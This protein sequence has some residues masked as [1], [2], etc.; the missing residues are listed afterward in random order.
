MIYAPPAHSAGGA[1]PMPP[2]RTPSVSAQ[3][4]SQLPRGGSLRMDAP[5]SSVLRML[6]WGR[7][8]AGR[9]KRLPHRGSWIRPLSER[10]RAKTEGVRPPTKFRIP[11]S[12]C[13]I[14][15][16]NPS[17]PCYNDILREDYVHPLE[18]GLCPTSGMHCLQCARV[19]SAR[20]WARDGR[21]RRQR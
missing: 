4:R 18:V 17:S 14:T 6:F 15:L 19:A 2:Q 7:S 21:I 9:A 10:R 16:A 20:P 5:V 13:R 1:F 12:E 11:H 8:P 3:A